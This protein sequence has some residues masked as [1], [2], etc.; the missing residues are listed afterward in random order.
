MS[1]YNLIFRLEAYL[2]LEE[3]ESYYNKISVALTDRFF[4]E[5]SK[6]LA[7]IEQQPKIFRERYKKTKIAPLYKFPYGIHYKI[8]DNLIIIYRV[9]HTKRYF[10]Q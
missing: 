10:K 3:V 7:F 2:D 5:F 9:L 4:G 1:N 8:N 6:T